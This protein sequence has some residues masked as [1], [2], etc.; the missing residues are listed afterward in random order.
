MHISKN[1]LFF[2]NK[3]GNLVYNYEWHKGCFVDKEICD[4]LE[5]R[6]QDALSELLSEETEK[7]LL[8]NGVLYEDK[9]TY[10]HQRYR[11]PEKYSEKIEAVYLHVTQKCN[12]RCSYCYNA[13]NLGQAD[14]LSYNEIEK[15][16]VS[17]KEIGVKH[18]ILTGGEPLLR[19]DLCQIAECLKLLKFRVG[20][21]S[22][23]SLLCSRDDI[24]KQIDYAII[25]LDTLNQ[26]ENNRRG[27]Q[28]EQ[29]TE[30]L[31]ML[32]IE[33]RKKITLRSV[34]GKKNF[35]SWRKVKAF[36]EQYGMS[37]VS[38]IQIPNSAAEIDD[39]P[40][41]SCIETTPEKLVLSGEGCG[42]CVTRFAINANGDVYPCQ[43]LISPDLLI[44]NIRKE[45]WL[46]E[47]RDSAI[48][49]S[50]I[51]WNIDRTARCNQCQWRYI[52]GGGCRAI[53]YNVYGDLFACTE[54]MCDY[55]KKEASER[56]Q[57]IIE[58]Y[59]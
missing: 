1:L 13:K 49:N 44:T 33:I 25:S 41:I 58:K 51:N 7:I 17:L 50:F 15:L 8:K 6:N 57:A 4:K 31:K 16:A 34:I 37:F 36:A 39:M 35:Q 2:K 11:C 10:E 53:A 14:E 26:E 5:N 29:V 24:L 56:M 38:V 42:A 40:E 43:A 45:N 54:C 22:N 46:E 23:G 19:E 21:L 55:K 12:L 47:F 28:I 18:M 59:I 48:T 9:K 30:S 32:P 3:K 27:L 20:L 52:C